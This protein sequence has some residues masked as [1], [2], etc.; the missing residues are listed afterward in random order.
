MVNPIIFDGGFRLGAYSKNPSIHYYSYS[1]NGVSWELQPL[2]AA[3]YFGKWCTIKDSLWFAKKFLK[4]LGPAREYSSKAYIKKLLLKRFFGGKAIDRLKSI[5]LDLTFKVALKDRF[6]RRVF[7]VITAS[8]RW[9]ACLLLYSG[10]PNES[11]NPRS[12]VEDGNP[13]ANAV[14]GIM[15]RLQEQGAFEQAYREPIYDDGEFS[16][17]DDSESDEPW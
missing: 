9:K 12:L 3:K 7:A 15:A 6:F 5:Q 10:L 16:G 8:K 4:I 1:N 11:W 14:R 13:Y 17:V 2:K